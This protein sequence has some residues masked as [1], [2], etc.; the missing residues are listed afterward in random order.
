MLEKAI[1]AHKLSHGDFPQSLEELAQPL[2]G[3][4]AAVK[5]EQLMDPWG[6]PYVLDLNQK[7]PTTGEPKI[8]SQGAN[9]GNPQGMIANW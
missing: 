9:P 7:H 4:P 2:D 5:A 3:K 1:G 8:Y 6:R